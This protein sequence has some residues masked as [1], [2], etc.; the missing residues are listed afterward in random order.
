M[1][2]QFGVVQT[3]IQDNIGIISVDKCATGL[4]EELA[5]ELACAVFDV[6]I[7]GVEVILLCG[8]TTSFLVNP[9]DAPRWHVV[10]GLCTQIESTSRPV[11][12][13]TEGRVEDAGL[14]IALACDYRIA[15]GSSY[16]GFPA[17]K[18]G[19]SFVGGAGR[20]LVRAVGKSAAIELLCTDNIDA[21]SAKDIGLVDEMLADVDV[22]AH[23]IANTA[24]YRKMPE[25]SASVD[26]DP[27]NV[28]IASKD[29]IKRSKKLG[30][31]ASAIELIDKIGVVSDSDADDLE[32]SNYIISASS[33]NFRALQHLQWAEK[34]A[35]ISGH[36]ATVHHPIKTVAVIGAGTMGSAIAAAVL[37]AGLPVTLIEQTEE[38][39]RAGIERVW[40]IYAKQVETGRLSE[41]QSE[42]TLRGVSA[43]HDW[44]VLSDVDLVI[45]AAFEDMDV[46]RS[47]FERLDSLAKKDA[48]L[49]TNTSYLDINEI[50]KFTKRP[51]SV[52]GLHFFSPAHIMRLLEVVKADATN[53][54]TLVVGVEFGR[55]IGKLPIVAGVC[56]GFIGNRIFSIYRRHAEYLLEDGATP[57][58]IDDAA[59]DFGFAMGPFAVA[60][61]SGLDIAWAMRK[62]RANTRNPLERYVSIPDRLCEA[63]RIG[64]KVGKGWYDYQD[65][66]AAPSP[67]VQ[68]MVE[69]GR[70]SQGVMERDFTPSDI[71]RR[72]LA[73]MAN[74]GAKVLEERISSRPS[75]I[76]LVFVNGYGFPRLKGGPMYAADQIGLSAILNEVLSAAHIGGA[77]SEPSRLLV[78]LVRTNR[79]F[80]E[81]QKD[82]T[83]QF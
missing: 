81:W 83:T 33:D 67:E 24:N 7:E 57:K 52:L 45:E 25:K 62:R 21:K 12:A 31:V 60:D 80:G 16:F 54:S 58:Q 13:F 29:A 65:G 59:Q 30:S 47:I 20:R 15:T 5:T 17:S 43:T 63:G 4:T 46:K 61:M 10:A 76:D 11:I 3:R 37:A 14:T 39:A 19:L 18:Y 40:G 69:L 49:A 75:D 82:N 23:V 9:D 38:A 55:R 28:I 53:E 22:V 42:A 34:Q 36:P 26:V 41:T 79:T 51:E 68:N 74:E 78:E 71:Q 1:S 6:D 27:A 56:D 73:V 77:G 72:L 66:R 48:V 35:S 50:G 32:R 64:R 8:G 70:L 2:N 44:E